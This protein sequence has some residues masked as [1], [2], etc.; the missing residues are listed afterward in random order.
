[1]VAPRCDLCERPFTVIEGGLDT[2]LFLCGNHAVFFYLP[3]EGTME[4]SEVIAEL[5]RIDRERDTVKKAMISPTMKDRLLEQLAVKSRELEAR[6]G[7]V[8][9]AANEPAAPAAKR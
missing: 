7:G 6:I 4:V 3:M 1:M 9:A 5:A 8:P 2:P